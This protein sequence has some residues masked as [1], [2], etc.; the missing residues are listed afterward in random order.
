MDALE[1]L[2]AAREIEDLIT[3]CCILCDDQDWTTFASLWTED[4]AFGIEGGST[5]EGRDA[6]LD[7]VTTCLP[8]DYVGKHLCSRSLIEFGP[9]GATAEAKTDVVWIA[10]NFENT[11]VSRYNDSLV[12]RDGRW[13]FRRRFETPV[14]YVA[15][16]PP[17]S[18]LLASSVEA[19]MR[20]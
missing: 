9:D 7:F 16:P 2:T 20:K 18:E 12:R 15:G 3:R 11:I 8:A 5:F 6:L 10:A 4:A 1:R 19:T 13:L 17:F 14:T